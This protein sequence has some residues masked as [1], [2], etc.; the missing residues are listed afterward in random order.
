MRS[1]P[2][3]RAALPA[4]ALAAGALCLAPARAHAQWTVFDPANYGY[5][6]AH[7]TQR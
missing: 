2:P 4:V 7:Y 1:R 3:R 6:V 5:N